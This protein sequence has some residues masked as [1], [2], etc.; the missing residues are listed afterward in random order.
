ADAAASRG[1]RV[2][3]PMLEIALLAVDVARVIERDELGGKPPS[4]DVDVSATVV[5][6][7]RE[8]VAAVESD[9]DRV[10]PVLLPDGV[11]VDEIFFVGASAGAGNAEGEH[12]EDADQH[13][14]E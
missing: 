6:P 14:A 1:R 9:Q 8:I 12:R 7:E 10:D 13:P 4:H 3:F 2:Q 11:I 5:A